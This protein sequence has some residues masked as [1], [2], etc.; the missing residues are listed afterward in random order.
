MINF[1]LNT[2]VIFE[3]GSIQKLKQMINLETVLVV[4][5]SS[6][7]YFADIAP[8]DVGDL[9]VVQSE[10]EVSFIDQSLRDLQG[11]V[12]R[13]IIG[14]GGGSV[15]DV[16]KSLAI[17]L[18]DELLSCRPIVSQN[19]SD[20]RSKINLILC[21]TTAGTGSEFSHSS[22]LYD[23]IAGRKTGIR[24]LRVAADLAVLDPVLTVS[25]PS[26]VT[27]STGFDTFAHAVETFI[28]RKSTLL[29]SEL[30]IAVIEKV[31]KYLPI[32]L[33]HP[34]DLDAREQ[35]LLASLICGFNLSTSSTCMP[36]RIQYSFPWDRKIPHGVGLAMI[37]PAWI[38]ETEERHLKFF[39]LKR[40]LGIDGTFVQ[41]V[42][43]FISKIGVFDLYKDL[44]DTKLGI[45]PTDV[46][47]DLASDPGYDEL[48]LAKILDRL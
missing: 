21:P 12:V 40:R 16:A 38:Q 26:N 29:T 32:A 48:V 17:C 47:G 14:V 25:L 45:K 42:D 43:D 11:K 9:I 24:G 37:Y 2:R 4:S 31:L 8:P 6:L 22:I 13:K 28:S 23:D 46:M 1:Q 15:L 20:R 3:R 34:D 35:L 10:P 18:E 5:R 36:H 27:A 44:F 30:S 39:E 19:F 41:F 7:Q 33:D